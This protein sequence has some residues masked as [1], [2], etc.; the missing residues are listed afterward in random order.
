MHIEVDFYYPESLRIYDL[1]DLMWV[2]CDLSYT[3][4]E[5][6]ILGKES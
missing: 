2:L 3:E 4:V 5:D 1:T 6:N